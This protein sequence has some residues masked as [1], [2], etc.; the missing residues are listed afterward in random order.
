MESVLTVVNSAAAAVQNISESQSAL[1]YACREASR[2]ERMFIT[3]Y[4]IAL[5]SLRKVFANNPSSV[6][7]S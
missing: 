1:Q 6:A 2:R 7:F 5:I 4:G 3:G